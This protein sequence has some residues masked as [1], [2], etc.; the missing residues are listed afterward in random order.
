MPG[1]D[2]AV[3]ADEAIEI[4]I[5]GDKSHRQ[6]IDRRPVRHAG[7][8]QRMVVVAE[9]R[10]DPVR[11]ERAGRRS[12]RETRTRRR[13]ACKACCD[14]LPGELRPTVDQR[15]IARRLDMRLA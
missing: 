6:A 13:G 8:I 12:Q 9:A 7:K 2:D 11:L 4:E 15:E 10:I 5:G 1:I 3:L 14:R